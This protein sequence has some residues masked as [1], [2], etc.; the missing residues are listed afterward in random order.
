MV[1]RPTLLALSGVTALTAGCAVGPDYHRPEAPV[2]AHYVDAR[3]AV[4]QGR[5]V[6]P[7]EHVTWWK[8]FDDPLLAQ[9]VTAALEQNLDIAQAAARVSQ[10]KAG[11][12]GAEGALLPMGAV[13]ASGARV[14]QSLEDPLGRL[15]S[16]HPGYDRWGKSFSADLSA[17]WELDL[18]GGLR[19]ERDASVADYQAS[20]AGA[21]AVRLAVVGQVADLYMTIRGIQARLAIAQRQVQ[22]QQELLLKVGLLYQRGLAAQTQVRAS[23]AAVAQA[24]AVVPAMEA[25]LDAAMNAMD[26]MLG[27]P[28]GTYRSQFAGEAH[29]PVTPKISSVGSPADLLWRRP[30]LIAA[31]R[32]LAAT[33]ARIGAAMAEYYPT[34]SLSALVGSA[35]TLSAGNLFSGDASHMAGVLGLRWRLF[36]F[37]RIDAQIALAKGQDSES[38]AAYKQ[39]VLRATEDVETAF[40][41]VLNREEISQALLQGEDSLE[42]VQQSAEAAYRRGAASR[43]DVLRAEESVLR[44]ADARAWA[45]AESARAAVAVFKAL[46]GGWQPEPATLAYR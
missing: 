10:A 19:R 5:A 9:L 15:L 4:G 27:A 33:N 21:S 30:D 40:S 22:T 17:S 29:I 46:G 26:V 1:L 41:A 2:A 11:V 23:E 34:F 20:E 12:A 6:L 25:G 38:L 44:M 39:A 36:D 13:S 37:Q 42:R 3:G 7:A 24:K 45:Q 28:P 31:E 32:R 35:S 8:T 14:Q 43:I 16:A 18:F